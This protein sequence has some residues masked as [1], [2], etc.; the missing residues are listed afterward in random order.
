M[1]KQNKL[2]ISI[3]IY[4]SIYLSIYIYIYIYIHG[5]WSQ[6]TR[7]TICSLPAALR[8]RDKKWTH[9]SS[10]FSWRLIFISENYDHIWKT[11]FYSGVTLNQVIWA[12][13][14]RFWMVMKH[15]EI[16]QISKGIRLH[17]HHLDVCCDKRVNK[18]LFEV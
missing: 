2:I 14:L 9:I 3:S 11:S 17:E 15:Q 12:K 18:K 16:P 1:P 13:K 4:L 8:W 7:V 6:H 10:Y 5:N